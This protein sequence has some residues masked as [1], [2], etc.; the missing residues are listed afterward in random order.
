VSGGGPSVTLGDSP[1][2][3]TFSVSVSHFFGTTGSTL[4]VT[5][6]ARYART[7]TDL[8]A[9]RVSDAQVAL[10]WTRNSTYTSVVVQRRTDEG[11]WVQVAKPSGNAYAYTDTT[12]VA[13][14]RYEYRVAGVGG[15]GQSAFTAPVTVYTTPNAPTGVAAVRDGDDIDVS[16]ATVPPY[17]TGFDVRD[18]VTVVATGVELP[19]TDIAPNP[20]VPHTYEVRGTVDGLEGVW[21]APSNT[22]QLLTAPNAPTGLSPNGGVAASDVDVRFSWVHNP[23]DSSP[24][25]VYEL[26]H[27]PV[28]GAWTTLSGTTASFRDVTLSEGDFEWQARTKGQHP[29]WSPWSAVATVAVITRPG[30][31]VTQPSSTWDLTVLTIEW[32]YL[33]AQSR[34]QS[35]WRVTLFD[36]DM[37]QLERRSGSGASGSAVLTTRI[38][39]SADYTVQVEAAT[40]SVWSSAATQSFTAVFLPPAAPFIEAEWDESTGSVTVHTD[41]GSAEGDPPDTVSMDLHRSVDGE[42]WEPIF[43]GFD[44]EQTVVDFE[45]LSYG[46]TRYRATAFT[47]TG[48]SAETVVTVDARSGAVWISGG[49]GFAVCGRLPFSPKVQ[50]SS[51]RSRAGRRYA[52]RTLPVAYAGEQ[53]TRQFQVSGMTADETLSGQ[54]TAA[55]DLLDAVAV[56]EEPTHL[57][58]DPDGRRVYGLVGAIDVS[59]E[60]AVAGTVRPWNGL[61]GYSFQL[62]DTGGAV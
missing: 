22:V 56:T 57:L 51:G 62:T 5:Y 27:R 47:A 28:G 26:R 43:T 18:G 31:A 60:N 55:V 32:S 46:D 11:S 16:A 29:D 24:Q 7:P 21:S 25:T 19:W 52:G 33:Q 17:V 37:A 54:I 4:T 2:T 13:G 45:S 40:G 20:A 42:T 38:V 41:A 58:R 14:H 48:A 39:N 36:A 53:V 34:P 9:N 35:A 44:P 12:T 1:T 10:S 15:S 59:R 8:V 23:V 3:R 50:V 49:P 61:W 30:V 6:P